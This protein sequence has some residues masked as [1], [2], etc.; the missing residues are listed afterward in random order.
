MNAIDR[1]PERL[2]APEGRDS[3]V[4]VFPHRD[5]APADFRALLPPLLREDLTLPRALGVDSEGLLSGMGRIL[6]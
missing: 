3:V 1:P 5:E 6:G 4:L 2:M